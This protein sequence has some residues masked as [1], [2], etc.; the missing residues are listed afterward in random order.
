MS[1]RKFLETLGSYLPALLVRQLEDGAREGAA[2]AVVPRRENFHSVCLFADISG[3]TKMASELDAE[4]LAKH[5]NSYFS[6]MTVIINKEG[7]DIFKFAGDAM[8]VLWEINPAAASSASQSALS[9]SS[10]VTTAGADATVETQTR[11]A[12][13]CACALQHY[14]NDAMLDENVSLSMSIGISVGQ[15]S[16]V[17][18]GGTLRRYEYLAVG[19][20]LVQAYAAEALAQKGEVVLS[21][22]AWRE[23]T[24]SGD[25]FRAQRMLAD[26]FVA[27]DLEAG[28]HTRLKPPKRAI[29]RFDA[30]DVDDAVYEKALRSYVPGALF[31]GLSRDSPEDDHWS[32]EPTA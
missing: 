30:L 29:R 27:L 12:T 3:F 5:L 14:L 4:T 31:P 9:S 25:N 24:R 7:G 15:V 22:S 6:Q 16:V 21:E 13:Q 11:R 17:H 10:T 2:Q 23:A 32:S 19:E 8:V 18:I 1:S 26:G 20:P 28:N